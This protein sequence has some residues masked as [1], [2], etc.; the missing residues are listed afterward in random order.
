MCASEVTAGKSD[1][2]AALKARELLPKVKMVRYGPLS[3]PLMQS[4]LLF[5]K[6]ST[7]I[8]SLFIQLLQTIHVILVTVY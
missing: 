6:G 2:K 8:D 7:L 1:S 4:S 3:C 5:H